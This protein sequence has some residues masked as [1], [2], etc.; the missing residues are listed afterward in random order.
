ML[1]RKQPGD[2]FIYSY[3]GGRLLLFFLSRIDTFLVCI[4]SSTCTQTGRIH[5]KA[6]LVWRPGNRG[7]HYDVLVMWVRVLSDSWQ[8]NWCIMHQHPKDF[9]CS[10]QMLTEHGLSLSTPRESKTPVYVD[11]SHKVLFGLSDT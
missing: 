6:I 4:Y 8:G 1:V 3:T 7:L 2:I 10:P 9:P 11:L 5:H